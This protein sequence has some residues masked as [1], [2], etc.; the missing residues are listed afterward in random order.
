MQNQFHHLQKISETGQSD[1]YSKDDENSETPVGENVQYASNIREDRA[2]AS[3]LSNCHIKEDSI[4]DE[5]TSVDD[6][7]KPNGEL[8]CAFETDVTDPRIPKTFLLRDDN[9][10]RPHNCSQ[11]GK[12]FARYCSY[13]NHLRTHAEEDIDS[14][15]DNI[16]HIDTFQKAKKLQDQKRSPSKHL[17]RGKSAGRKFTCTYCHKICL[18]QSALTKHLLIHTGERAYKCNQCPKAY[19]QNIHLK[20][21]IV[22]HTTRKQF[23]CNLCES[24]FTQ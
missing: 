4:G 18:Y 7:D 2:S 14:P 9:H 3:D 13:K 12:S 24:T 15:T 20:R 5:V 8:Q 11:C 17:D 1:G 16:Q 21:H 22:T 19:K 10:E 6:I 23:K